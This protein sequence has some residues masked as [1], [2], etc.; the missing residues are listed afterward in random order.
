[1]NRIPALALFLALGSAQ[2]ESTLS[3]YG[4]VYLTVESVEA[5]DE[6]G[7]S[8]D[9]LPRRSRVSDQS[10]LLGVRGVEEFGAG[11]SAFFQ[12]ETGFRPDQ[13]P[14]TFAARNSGVGLQGAWG[15]VVAGRWDTPFKTATIAVDPFSDL[16][17]GGITAALNGSGVRNVQGSFD[18]RDQNVVQYWSPAFH[19]LALRLSHSVNEARTASLNPRRSGASITYAREGLYAGYAYDDL[20]DVG[21]ASRVPRSQTGHAFFGTYA[22]GALKLGAVFEEFRRTAFSKQTAWMANATWSWGRH[23]LIY[24]YQKAKNGDD[25]DEEIV[26]AAPRALFLPPAQPVCSVNV[27]AYQYAFSRR[28]WLLAQYVKID[29]NLTATCNFGVNPLTIR[30]GHDPQGAAVG[31]RHNF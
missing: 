3:L 8:S 9:P 12:L 1:M 27:F 29:N 30:G 16:T 14:T 23:Q 5:R 7:R 26:P 25:V 20:R 28:T 21:F 2:A 24:E 15:T 31:I 10:S 13:D 11:R 18:R 22:I 4:R 19:G 6:G 17:P